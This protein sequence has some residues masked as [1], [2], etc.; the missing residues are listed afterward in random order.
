[1]ILRIIAELLKN[2]SVLLK[3]LEYF[4]NILSNYTNIFTVGFLVTRVGLLGLLAA[5]QRLVTKAV[6]TPL[7]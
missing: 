7:S 6:K 5:L 3:R 4:L 2:S 1:M